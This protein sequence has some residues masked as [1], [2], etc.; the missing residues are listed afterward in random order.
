MTYQSTDKESSVV[1]AG[2]QFCFVRET[3]DA[4]SVARAAGGGAL[5]NGRAW[6]PSPFSSDAG[7]SNSITLAPATRSFGLL[8]YSWGSASA[9]DVVAAWRSKGVLPPIG[10]ADFARHEFDPHLACAQH[11]ADLRRRISK[12]R[13]VW[14]NANAPMDPIETYLLHTR[15]LAGCPAWPTDIRCGTARNGNPQMIF[16]IVNAG[17]EFQ[18]IHITE[19]TKDGQK[20]GPKCRRMLGVSSGGFVEIGDQN[21]RAAVVGEGVESTIA[22]CAVLGVPRGLATL[23]SANM[24]KLVTLPR[25]IESVSICADHDKAGLRAAENLNATLKAQWW[26]FEGVEIFYPPKSETDFNDYLRT[27]GR[28]N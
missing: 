10:A 11:E 3:N 26:Q 5:G 14:R 22:A 23:S 1:E 8:V 25:N 7:S 12:A 27:H 18:G 21:C 17:G 2:A 24:A 20:A 28:L 4:V 13:H 19:L 16:P 6:A 15:G 9:A